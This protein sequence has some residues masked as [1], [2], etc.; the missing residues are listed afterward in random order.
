MTSR[1]TMIGTGMLALLAPNN[2]PSTGCAQIPTHELAQYRN[3]F[4]EVRVTFE[5]I[6]IDFAEAKHAAEQRQAAR[7]AAAAATV[8][9]GIQPFSTDLPNSAVRQADAVEVRR[10]AFTTIDKFN[11]VLVTLAE[12]KS[13]DAIKGAAGGFVEAAGRFVAT[14]AGSAVPGLSAL[15]GVV[16]T[17]AGEFEKAR[18]R[19]EFAQAIRDG[20]PKIDQILAALSAERADHYKLRVA[21]AN[22]RQIEIIGEMKQAAI[23]VRDVVAAHRAPPANDP[24][25]DLQKALDRGI[26]PLDR[27]LKLAY[28]TTAGAPELGATAK[29][30]ADLAVARLNDRAK[31][32]AANVAQV[33]RLGAALIAYGTMIERTRRA[34]ARLA[35]ALDRPPKFEQTADAL[36]AIAFEVRRDI[37][38]FRAARAAA[39]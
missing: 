7:A 33:E 20:A 29:V 10:E 31:E 13:V 8:S 17:V 25:A 35:A 28:A 18:L 32:F 37:E 14:A 4:A 15:S 26:E 19:E 3:A 9:A 12:G 34:L 21:A 38:A 30:V 6:L 2:A 39:R 22:L 1:L 36:F 16:R 11:N 5:E 23:N 24:L 27:P